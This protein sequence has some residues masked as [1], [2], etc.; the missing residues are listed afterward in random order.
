M[1]TIRSKKSAPT[2]RA[3]MPWLKKSGM[4]RSAGA[5]KAVRRGLKCASPRPV[6]LSSRLLCGRR[7]LVDRR[8]S[9][10][11]GRSLVIRLVAGVAVSGAACS[12]PTSF[13]ILRASY[14]PGDHLILSPADGKIMEI[15]EIQDPACDRTGVG[16]AHLLVGF[17]S[18]YPAAPVAGHGAEDHVQ[19]RL[20]LD[21][22][23]P[24]A[25]F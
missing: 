20:F 22:R 11:G 8:R 5:K 12:A 24:K 2:L 13:A 3:M 6:G 4:D 19:E 9:P 18:A 1:P 25:L 23:H 14:R 21:A 15:V 17:R 7:A 16:G 10:L